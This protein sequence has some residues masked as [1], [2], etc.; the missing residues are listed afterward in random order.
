MI[1][2]VLFPLIL[3]LGFLT[4]YTDIKEGKIKNRHLLIALIS[5][6]ILYILLIVFRKL[7]IN[8]FAR[9]IINFAIGTGIA[10]FLWFLG[11]WSAG[12]AKL[13]SIYMLILPVHYFTVQ[14]FTFLTLLINVL[15]PVAIFFILI[16]VFGTSTR[17]KMRIL[18]GYFTIEYIFSTL[19]LIFSLG[20]IIQLVFSFLRIPSNLILSMLL[21]IGINR[22]FTKYFKVMYAY[23]LIS[24]VRIFFQ[25][26]QLITLSF[27]KSFFIFSLG[28]IILR[29]FIF[30]LSFSLFTK[31]Y[32]TKDLKPGMIPAENVVKDNNFFRKVP[33]SDFFSS[34]QIRNQ[35]YL[36]NDSIEGLNKKDIKFLEKKFKDINI[37]QTIPFAPFMFLGV[38]ITIFFGV[39]IIN[40]VLMYMQ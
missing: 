36:L 25:W 20:W 17:Q 39:D 13:F 38:L 6:L 34:S 11:F 32:K 1:A 27:W 21:I 14:A 33:M 29:G 18:R 3:Y 7:D 9:T 10:V 40:L 8:V 4:S 30:D 35:Q 22:L 5:V 12:D 23:S 28:F 37:H 31:K 15:V 19:L 2:Y 16:L 24:I 26:P